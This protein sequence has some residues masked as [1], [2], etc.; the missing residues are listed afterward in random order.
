MIFPNLYW[1]ES[2]LPL[3]QNPLESACNGEYRLYH[4]WVPKSY[5][6]PPHLAFSSLFQKQKDPNYEP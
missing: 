2:I 5:K 6:T 3:P 4:S 1:V